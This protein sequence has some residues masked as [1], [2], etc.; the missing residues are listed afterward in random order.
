MDR[1]NVVDLPPQAGISDPLTEM[2]R[3]GAR[4]LDRASS[5]GRGSRPAGA[6][7]GS[8]DRGW[9]V[10]RRTQRLPPGTSAS[11]RAGSGAWSHSEGPLA[12]RRAGHVPLGPG[13]VLRP[14]KPRAGGGAALALSQGGRDGRDGRGTEGSGRRGRGRMQEPSN[15][16]A[17]SITVAFWGLLEISHRLKPRRGTMHGTQAWIWSLETKYMASGESRGG[18]V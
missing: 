5:R 1:D 16:S 6:L 13:A 3:N 12:R 17:V 2:L 15:G 18:S 14:Q 7:P 4:H 10:R 11:N 9:P 8:S